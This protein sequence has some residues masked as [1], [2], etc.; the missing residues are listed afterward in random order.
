MGRFACNFRQAEFPVKQI[1][2]S[3]ILKVTD[4]ASGKLYNLAKTT[5]LVSVLLRFSSGRGKQEHTT[6]LGC[7]CGRGSAE[8]QT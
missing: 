8:V 6:Y 7:A 4:G 5:E 1:L 3:P 2:I